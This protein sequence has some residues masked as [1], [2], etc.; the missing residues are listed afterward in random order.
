MLYSFGKSEFLEFKA[1]RFHPEKR[2]IFN[3]TFFR[4]PILGNLFGQAA[5]IPF[6]MVGFYVQKVT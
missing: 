2:P 6:K 4:F 1:Y 5:I 3:Q